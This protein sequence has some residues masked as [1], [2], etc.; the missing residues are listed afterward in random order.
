M[1]RRCPRRGRHG[2]SDRSRT[3]GVVALPS[4]STPLAPR[5]GA[6]TETVPPSRLRNGLSWVRMCGGSGASAGTL[7]LV[8]PR[9]ISPRSRGNSLRRRQRPRTER[10]TL[11]SRPQ[12]AAARRL[13]VVPHLRQ[14]P[15]L[16]TDEDNNL[17]EAVAGA[18]TPAAATPTISL[19][20]QVAAFPPP[21]LPHPSSPPCTPQRNP[22]PC[23]LTPSRRKAHCLRASDA[24]AYL[25]RQQPDS[26]RTPMAT[27][28]SPRRAAC[29]AR[30][31]TRRAALHPRPPRRPSLSPPLS[32]R[33][34]QFRLTLGPQATLSEEQFAALYGGALKLA[35]AGQALTRLAQA[36][37]HPRPAPP[38]RLISPQASSWPKERRRR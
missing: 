31:D 2:S 21:R 24:A 26:T 17:R 8:R 30:A 33:A 4:A 6:R 32:A 36:R 15:G 7:Q 27:S 22:R 20:Q 18:T 9:A 10:P 29:S 38:R 14:V 19:I 11:N 3:R 28:T 13:S 16:L 5:A 25:P 1:P 23:C 37:P 35:D 34:A 12:A